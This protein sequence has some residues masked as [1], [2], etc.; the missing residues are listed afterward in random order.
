[1][2]TTACPLPNPAADA[3]IN[4]IGVKGVG[5]IGF[6][7]VAQAIANAFYHATGRRIRDFPIT[8]D[9]LL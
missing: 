8:P 6:V 5:E 1:M 4:P 9:K 7:G 2:S 3:H